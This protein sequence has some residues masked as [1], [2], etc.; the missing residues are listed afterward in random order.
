[1]IKNEHSLSSHLFLQQFFN[2]FIIHVLNPFIVQELFLRADMFD[3]LKSGIV[4]SEFGLSSSG[5]V[6]DCGARVVSDV[7]FISTFWWIENVLERSF[8]S[9]GSVIV[10]RRLDVVRWDNCCCGHCFVDSSSVCESE[11]GRSW[12][13]LVGLNTCPPSC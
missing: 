8:I 5:V 3:E 13:N 11:L 7:M 10:Q 1:M 6:N 2:L 4:E 9:N 12:L